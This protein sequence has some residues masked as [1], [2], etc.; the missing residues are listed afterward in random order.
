MFDALTNGY[1]TEHSLWFCGWPHNLTAHSAWII[2]DEVSLFYCFPYLLVSDSCGWVGGWSII[3]THILCNKICGM[4]MS[5]NDAFEYEN[6]LR[7]SC[8]TLML[9]WAPRDNKRFIIQQQYSVF[10]GIAS[11]WCEYS[12]AWYGIIV[13]N[14]MV[15]MRLARL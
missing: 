11:I 5:M 6:V 7:L 12:E 3:C 8:G 10:S 2:C 4:M 15:L 13:H 1:C 9:T 14:S